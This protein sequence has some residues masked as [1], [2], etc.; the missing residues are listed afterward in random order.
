M[1]RI[2]KKKFLK[3]LRLSAISNQLKISVFNFQLLTAP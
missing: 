1:G 2:L 3:K